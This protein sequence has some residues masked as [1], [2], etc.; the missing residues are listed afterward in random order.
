MCV[1]FVDLLTIVCK[2]LCLLGFM[3]QQIVNKLS[4]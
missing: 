1:D 4:T 2:E 3:I